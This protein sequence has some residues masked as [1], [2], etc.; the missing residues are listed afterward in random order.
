MGSGNFFIDYITFRFEKTTFVHKMLINQYLLQSQDEFAFCSGVWDL[1]I[2]D[3]KLRYF[4][5]HVLTEMFE[6]LLSAEIE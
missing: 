2:G 6:G 4:F 5:C 1:G 3:V